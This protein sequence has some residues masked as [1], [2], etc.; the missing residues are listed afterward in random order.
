M[1]S[2]TTRPPARSPRF[3]PTAPQV[4]LPDQ[5]LTRP[6]IA[7]ATA[8]WI[9]ERPAIPPPPGQPAP[10]NPPLYPF[11]D[12]GTTVFQDC[13]AGLADH[14]GAPEVGTDLT[15]LRFLRMIETRHNPERIAT[16]SEP[17]RIDSTQLRTR[18][19]G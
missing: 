10:A 12:Y 1:P 9:T 19:V 14:P 2:S 13:I 17:A 16:L 4:T 11:P 7:G 3:A 8:E 5:S 15:G 18:Y 6:R